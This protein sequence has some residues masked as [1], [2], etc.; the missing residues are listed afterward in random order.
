M[1]YTPITGFQGYDSFYAE[2]KDAAGNS[3]VSFANITIGAPTQLNVEPAFS[4]LRIQ[5]SEVVVNQQVQTLSFVMELS[6]DAR[7]C[8]VFTVN[9][10]QPARDC[11][12]LFWHLTCI[13]VHVSMC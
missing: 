2:I 12:R 10:K 3:V 4:G 1:L 9:I 7:T 6:P 13:E 5:K 8:E 11:N